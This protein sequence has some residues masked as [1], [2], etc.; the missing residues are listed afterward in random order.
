MHGVSI[1]NS[2][3]WWL[4]LGIDVGVSKKP[5][6]PHRAELDGTVSAFQERRLDRSLRGSQAASTWPC[7]TCV[8][9]R[10]PAFES[11]DGR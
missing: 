6:L 9:G 11:P 2:T 10:T 7:S 1:A 5:G 8:T 4:P 3:I